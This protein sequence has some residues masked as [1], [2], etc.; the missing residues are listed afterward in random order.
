[1]EMQISMI[2]K[3]EIWRWILNV[4]VNNKVTIC[5]FK[6]KSVQVSAH[7]AI[8]LPNNNNEIKYF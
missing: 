2:A 1:M 5:L 8:L 6:K 3:N 7:N 4:Y